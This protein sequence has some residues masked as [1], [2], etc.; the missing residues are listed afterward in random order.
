MHSSLLAALS[1]L[2]VSALA[3]APHL[4]AQGGLAPTGAP[5]QTMR[6]LDQIEPRTPIPGGTTAFT[7]SAA[8]SYKLCGELTVTTGNVLAV[9]TSHVTIDLNGFSIIGG[10]SNVGILLNTGVSNVTIRNG[11]VRSCSVGVSGSVRT[12]IRVEQV[13]FVSNSAGG[14]TIGDGGSLIGCQAEGNGIF[15]LRAAS[16]CVARDCQSHGTTGT[17]GTNG[18][19]IEV[20]SDANVSGCLGS[21]NAGNGIQ[22]GARARIVNCTANGNSLN[23]IQA[24]TGSLVSD[25]NAGLNGGDGINS[26]SANSSVSILRCNANLN[27]GDGIECGTGCLVEGNHCRG[28]GNGAGDG[29]G[30]HIT[31]TDTRVEGNM[32]ASNDRGID[33]T[34]AGCLI[35]RNTA[36]G[37][38]LNYTIAANNRYGPVID[39][40][41][42][43]T[44]LVSGSVA[45]DTTT[46]SH[47]WANFA[48]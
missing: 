21:E 28:N 48:Y 19:G 47:P 29:A 40:T 38:T 31:N 37:N 39:I 5:N 9:T 18:N 32:V 2:L 10:G 15:G 41:T 17:T 6:A 34:S 3:L 4:P 35:I 30:I 7:I 1:A 42:S 45:A 33:I 43:G 8:G 16:Q 26:P 25:C 44:P 20:G 13:R 14:V 11:T 36:V 27:T 22:V 24:S 46:S 12:N 23:G